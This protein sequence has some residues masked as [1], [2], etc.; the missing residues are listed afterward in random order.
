MM[1]SAREAQL[2][3]PVS[4]LIFLIYMILIW[5]KPAT[6]CYTDTRIEARWIVVD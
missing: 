3:A 4:V 5:L 2:R 1:S 6:R